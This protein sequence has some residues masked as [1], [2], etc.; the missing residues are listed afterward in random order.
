MAID[1]TLT[2]TASISCDNCREDLLK[3]DLNKILTKRLG[4]LSNP[5]FWCNERCLQKWED[6]QI[7]VI[8]VETKP[9]EGE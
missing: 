1:N 4:I 7:K 8:F 3:W 9:T 2:I 5:H 6:K